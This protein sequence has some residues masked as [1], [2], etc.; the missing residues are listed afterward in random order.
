MSK[1]IPSAAQLA[2]DCSLSYQAAL[3]GA[4]RE[5]R[6]GVFRGRGKWVRVIANGESVVDNGELEFKGTQKQLDDILAKYSY[7]PGLEAIYI[8]GGVNWG[9]NLSAFHSGDY[10]PWVTEW[11]VNILVKE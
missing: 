3:A 5:I 4:K 1:T 11:A 10:E 6:G 8:E 9:E 7:L 2:R